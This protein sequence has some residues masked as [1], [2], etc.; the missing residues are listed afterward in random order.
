V[1]RGKLDHKS[2]PGIICQVK[3][4]KNYRILF[5]GGVLKDYLMLQRFQVEP[6]KKAEHYGLEDAL[7]NWETKSKI[8]ICEALCA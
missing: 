6:I 4:L 7:Q 8:S 2:V 5:K 1:D 3:E